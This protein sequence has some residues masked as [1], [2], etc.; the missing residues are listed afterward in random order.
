MDAEPSGEKQREAKRA[1]LGTIARFADVGKMLS[2]EPAEFARQLIVAERWPELLLKTA[3]IDDTLRRQ[4]RCALAGRSSM[5]TGAVDSRIKSRNSA[6]G[7]QLSRPRRVQIQTSC[8]RYCGVRG[9]LI[10]ALAID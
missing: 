2:N 7:M 9:R 4:T 10:E 5:R 6:C 8:S 1:V 3:F